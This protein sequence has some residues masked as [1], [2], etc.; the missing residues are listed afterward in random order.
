MLWSVVECVVT[1]SMCFGVLWSVVAEG[2]Y[3][4]V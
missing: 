1:D 4:C 2:M 3:V